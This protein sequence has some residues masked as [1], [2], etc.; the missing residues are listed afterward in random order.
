VFHGDF[1]GS[2][3]RGALEGGRGNWGKGRGKAAGKSE[4]P[5]RIQ[6]YSEGLRGALTRFSKKRLKKA[7]RVSPGG[8]GKRVRNEIGTPIALT[9]KAKNLTHLSQKN[10]EH[11][12]E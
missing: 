7:V 12:L 6:A 3:N 9:G 10:P 5:I 4:K 11:V 1:A 8:P 2:S